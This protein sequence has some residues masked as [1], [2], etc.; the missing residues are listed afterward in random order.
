MR[1]LHPIGPAEK[2]IAQGTY[3][4]YANM[5]WHTELNDPPWIEVIPLTEPDEDGFFEALRSSGVKD[6]WMIHQLPDGSRLIRADRRS[7]R[8]DN[9][10]HVLGTMLRDADGRPRWMQMRVYVECFGRENLRG[11][12]IMQLFAWGSYLFFDDHAAMQRQTVIRQGNAPWDMGDIEVAH[13]DLPTG[14]EVI[15]ERLTIGMEYVI[16]AGLRRVGENGYVTGAADPAALTPGFDA[17]RERESAHCRNPQVRVPVFAPANDGG[18][19]LHYGP[20]HLLHGKLEHYTITYIEPVEYPMIGSDRTL[21]GHRCALMIDYE[22]GGGFG[23]P[24]IY[25]DAGIMLLNGTGYEYHLTMFE[26]P[27]E[28]PLFTE[29]HAPG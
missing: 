21:A 9:G 20:A 28:Y 19:Q 26:Q 12:C 4:C 25:G 1:L 15:F 17:V 23:Y 8:A 7:L 29:K 13:M 6:C 3:T 24:V 2:L 5:N 22:S 18:F 14:Y 11:V 27:G 10:M 16:R